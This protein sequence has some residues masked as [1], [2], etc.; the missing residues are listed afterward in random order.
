[1]AVF[2]GDSEGLA[3]RVGMGG[4]ANA[5]GSSSAAESPGDSEDGDRLS[6]KDK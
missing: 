5:S 3:A 2:G 1:M 4:S 6:S